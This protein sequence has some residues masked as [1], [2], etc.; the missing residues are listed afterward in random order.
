MIRRRAVAPEGFP[1]GAAISLCDGPAGPAGTTSLPSDAEHCH[2]AGAVHTQR[3]NQPGRRARSP[4]RHDV[5]GERRGAVPSGR[6]CSPAGR[7]SACT[8]GEQRQQ[9]QRRCRAMRLHA[10]APEGFHYSAALSLRDG[11]AAPAGLTSLLSEAVSRHRDVS[12]CE[13]GQQRLQALHLLRSTRCSGLVSKVTTCCADVSA[14]DEGQQL[15]QALRHIR[16]RRRCAIVS[17]VIARC[18]NISAYEE[19]QQRQQT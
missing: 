18:A 1:Y 8:T 2:R 5:S 17:E 10:I 14:C 16:A 12:A 7:P 4:S 6:M 19:G 15:Q 11:P 13:E 3:C 9:A